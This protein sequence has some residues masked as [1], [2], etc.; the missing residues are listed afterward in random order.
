MQSRESIRE[1]KMKAEDQFRGQYGKL[2][3]QRGQSNQKGTSYDGKKWMD[4]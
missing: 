1:G 3:K 2:G 4:P